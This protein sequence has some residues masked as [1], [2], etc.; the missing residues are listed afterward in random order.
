MRLSVI[1]PCLV[2]ATA[3]PSHIQP[4]NGFLLFVS[5]LMLRAPLFLWLRLGLNALHEKR[6]RR[7]PYGRAGLGALSANIQRPAAWCQI[8]QAVQGQLKAILDAQFLEQP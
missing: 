8:L 1:S 3:A 7:L 4:R 2:F 6:A 5:E